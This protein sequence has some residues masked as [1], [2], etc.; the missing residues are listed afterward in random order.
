MRQQ[1][2]SWICIFHIE[3]ANKTLIRASIASARQAL[4]TPFKTI[5]SAPYNLASFRAF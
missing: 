3:K 5:E 2:Q 4:P 1:K